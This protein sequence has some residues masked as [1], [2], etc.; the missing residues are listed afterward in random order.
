MALFVIPLHVVE[1][2]AD[3]TSPLGSV[4]CLA[5]TFVHLVKS[6]LTN[7]NGYYIFALKFEN[8][9]WF[10]IQVSTCTRSWAIAAFIFLYHVYS[11]WLIRT[12]DKTNGT[13][14]A[15]QISGLIPPSRSLLMLTWI[16]IASMLL[17][18]PIVVSAN[19]SFIDSDTCTLV[20]QI[21]FTSKTKPV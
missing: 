8:Y 10:N 16:W 3:R 18:V 15:F 13:N 19:G 5:G 17:S 14:M 21:T 20:N 1:V 4:I 2:F 9:I 12:E 7:K 6:N 11:G